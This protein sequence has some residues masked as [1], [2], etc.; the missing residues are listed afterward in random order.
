MA[1]IRQRES[2]IELLRLVVMAFIVLHHFIFHGLGLYR[3]I[4]FGEAQTLSP[5]HVNYSLIA[6]SFLIA[7]VNVFILIS[8]YFGIRFKARSFVKLF[9]IVSFF[10]VAG[11]CNY[12]IHNGLTGGGI[13]TL[14]RLIERAVCVISSNK[15]W[16]IQLYFI[17]MI[18][19]GPIN[20]YVESASKKS[21][22][23]A[24]AVMLFINVY[25]GW[26]WKCE[27]A[28]NGYNLFNFV[29][30]YLIGRYL[31]LHY[32][33]SLAKRWDVLIFLGCSA[34]TACLAVFMNN[35]GMDTFRA[36][37]YNSPFII[38]AAIALLMLFTKFHFSSK[39]INYAAASS[40]AIYLVQ[41]GVFNFYKPIKEMYLTAG[42]DAHFWLMIPIF[43]LISMITPLIVDKLRLLC[44]GKLEDKASDVLDKHVFKKYFNE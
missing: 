31:K 21:L 29:M 37:C 34:A 13:G 30:L 14:L 28:T 42:F 8:G 38:M 33:K 7:G 12:V 4:A 6:D 32:T 1:Q 40:L 23:V 19:S 44:F 5:A 20:K 43:F 17:L 36:L 10:S 16:F 41:D 3:A 9:G 39:A 24:I 11:F 2:N 15:Y 26:I 27:F 22:G 35:H 18:F 25:M